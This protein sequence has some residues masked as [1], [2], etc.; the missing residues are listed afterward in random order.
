MNDAGLSAQAEI[1]NFVNTGQDQMLTKHSAA[2]QYYLDGLR[3]ARGILGPIPLLIQ[4][5]SSRL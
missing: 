2:A 4:V 3:K 5:P 1:G